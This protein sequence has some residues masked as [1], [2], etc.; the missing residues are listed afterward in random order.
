MVRDSSVFSVDSLASYQSLVELMIL[1]LVDLISLKKNQLIVFVVDSKILYSPR[2]SP[3]GSPPHT[4]MYILPTINNSSSDDKHKLVVMTQMQTM[5]T[6]RVSNIARSLRHTDP[7]YSRGIFGG[8]TIDKTLNIK[9]IL[10]LYIFNYVSSHSIRCWQAG[11]TL[12]L[13][14][15]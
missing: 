10:A 2:E 7:R 1:V 3:Y 4:K 6:S 14:L 12:I 8:A 13:S 5:P 11:R 15:T 9:H